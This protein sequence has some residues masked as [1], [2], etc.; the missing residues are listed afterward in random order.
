MTRRCRPLR[1]PKTNPMKSKMLLLLFFT[2][3]RFCVGNCRR[4][5]AAGRKRKILAGEGPA[6]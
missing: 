3:L 1:L 4:F 2:L 5:S 6:A